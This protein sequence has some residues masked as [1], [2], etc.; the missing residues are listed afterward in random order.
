MF[1]LPVL[2]LSDPSPVFLTYSR[3]PNS[4][5]LLAAALLSFIRGGGDALSVITSGDPS[6]YATPAV[7]QLGFA[8]AA[9]S[10][11]LFL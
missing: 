10:A 1:V 11:Y 4:Q 2:M 8:L 7:A 6:A 5:A 9:I 3:P